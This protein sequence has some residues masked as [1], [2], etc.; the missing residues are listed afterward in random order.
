MKIAIIK[1]NFGHRNSVFWQKTPSFEGVDYHY[2]T[3][4]QNISLRNV[5][6]HYINYNNCLLDT[7][8][9]TNKFKCRRKAKL[10]KILPD[11]F[12]PNY[13]YYIWMD[14]YFEIKCS[15]Q[16]I[17]HHSKLDKSDSNFCFFKHSE[18]DCVYEEAQL[19]KKIKYDDTS[20][21][22]FQMESYKNCFSYP[23]KNGLYECT[24]FVFK[25]TEKSKCIRMEWMNHINRFSSRD[26]LSIPF[27]LR[28]FDETPIILEG[29]ILPGREG[30]NPYF[31]SAGNH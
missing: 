19:I 14:A 26:Q 22:D 15:P 25:N 30:D 28:Q 7:P 2:F 23:E 21:V 3:D 6:T 5:T 20:M 18:R 12:L 8:V 24:C 29:R 31:I 16:L 11:L 4:H 27:V 10:Y 13:D 17:I 9:G 1:A